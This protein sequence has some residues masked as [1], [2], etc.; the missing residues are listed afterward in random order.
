MRDWSIASRGNAARH[1]F[2][3]L[4]DINRAI[5]FGC[6]CAWSYGRRCDLVRLPDL[7]VIVCGNVG[8]ANGDRTTGSIDEHAAVRANCEDFIGEIAQVD[9]APLCR[10]TASTN[11]PSQPGL[12]LREWFRPRKQRQWR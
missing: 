6:T 7:R 12:Q 1:Q 10:K 11:R 9:V 2:G 4:L 8:E 3:G 5:L